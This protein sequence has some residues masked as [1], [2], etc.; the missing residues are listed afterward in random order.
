MNYTLS[1]DGP[2][3]QFLWAALGKV[4]AEQSFGV[5]EGLKA[6]VEAQ[7]RAHADAARARLKSELVAELAPSPA[8]SPDQAAVPSPPVVPE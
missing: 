5:M 8:G 6:Q 7:E 4:P 1:V 3:F 2:T